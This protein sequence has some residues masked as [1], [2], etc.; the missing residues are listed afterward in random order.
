MGVVP[1]QR[2]GPLAIVATAAVAICVVLYLMSSQGPPTG[3]SISEAWAYTR[4]PLASSSSW[5]SKSRLQAD[6][7]SVYN[8]TLGFQKVFA[9]SLPDR[10]DKR[11]AISLTARLTGFDVEWIDGVRGESI[12]DKAVPLGIDR[13]PFPDNPL[14]CWRGHMNAI[15]RYDTRRH[16]PPPRSNSRLRHAGR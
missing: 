15:R 8:S 12:P 6:L 14:G 5:L 11:D 3:S 16:F 9:I 4:E 10:S 2:R 7:K 1:L 13:P